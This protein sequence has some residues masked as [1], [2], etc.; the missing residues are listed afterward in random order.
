MTNFDATSKTFIYRLSTYSLKASECSS[1]L[2]KQCTA[3]GTREEYETACQEWRNQHPSQD[4]P[5]IGSPAWLEMWK[6]LTLFLN[7]LPAV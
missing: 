5:P 1:K 3:E 7:R 2:Q 6:K 4:C